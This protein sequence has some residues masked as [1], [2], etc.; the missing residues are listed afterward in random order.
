MDIQLYSL[1][2]NICACAAVLVFV[3][4]I[5]RDGKKWEDRPERRSGR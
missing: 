2:A 4:L 5:L 3:Y 1:L